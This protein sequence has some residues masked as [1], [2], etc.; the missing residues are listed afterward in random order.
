MCI[1]DRYDA[2]K[3]QSPTSYFLGKICLARKLTPQIPEECLGEQLSRHYNK[4]I[5]NSSRYNQF[6]KI[7]NL[8][9]LL[10]T[11]EQ[12]GQYRDYQTTNYKS[13]NHTNYNRQ[14]NR[15]SGNYDRPNRK[16]NNN[17]SPPNNHNNY[18][19]GPNN[20]NHSGPN[21]YNYRGNNYNQRGNQG[22]GDRRD[23]NYRCQ[24]NYT[25][26]NNQRQYHSRSPTHNSY[27]NQARNNNRSYGG[28]NGQ[29]NSD[30]DNRQETQTNQPV[31]YTHLD[32]Y[33][34]QT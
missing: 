17:N 25:V 28:D 32:V 11:C 34:R 30:P 20:N 33:K 4:E 22:G 12:T 3:G 24:V 16:N 19:R 27:H 18:N 2:S 7:Q 14:N 5:E 10:E 9:S 6:K 29:V 21:N 15:D 31:S 8:A 26:A 1:R 23:Q 13:D